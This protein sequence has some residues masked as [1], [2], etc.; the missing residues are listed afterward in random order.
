MV[1]IIGAGPVGNYLASK[2]VG[3]GLN[4][5]VYEEHKNVGEP[6]ACTG[7]ITGYL[8]D[9]VKVNKDYVINKI[10]R[11]NVYS[12]EGKFVSIKLKENYI[13]DRTLFD[14]HLA[15]VAEADGV[16]YH[17]GWRLK[18]LKKMKGESAHSLN[19][20]NGRERFD[21]CV[22]GADG[23]STIVGRNSGMYLGRKFVAGHQARVRMKEK[24]DPNVVDF[25]LNE[26]NY[27]AWMV[28]EDERISRIGVASHKD[29]SK[30]FNDLL[31]I[32][33]GKVLEWQS[34]AIPIYDPKVQIEK[35]GVYLVGDAATQ[36][37]ATTYGGII[38]GMH[39]SDVL[40]DVI[41]N[42][43]SEGSYQRGVKKGIGRTLWTHLMM[44]KIMN[45]FTKEDYNELIR[46]CE[47]QS[48][49]D[50]IYKYD[51][52]YPSKLLFAMLLKQPNFVKFASCL[53]KKEIKQ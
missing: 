50:V 6:V 22:V 49:K 52:E 23:P 34:G 41:L 35:E 37:K 18:S 25:F 16:K 15:E 53:F 28:P 31:K 29:V 33:P 21:S 8:K 19:F 24:I 30:Y 12:P 9:L 42:E 36:V 39:A 46:L 4:V 26:G 27:I 7:I 32:R 10:N 43:K 5:N 13:V 14:S 45:K 1:S 11:T 44:R 2:L 17:N 51:R 20:E 38:P 40:S 48:V 3:E 47:K